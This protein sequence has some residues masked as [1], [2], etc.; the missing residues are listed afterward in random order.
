MSGLTMKSRLLT[1][2]T[3]TFMEARQE[4]R[5]LQRKYDNLKKRTD[6][7]RKNATELYAQSQRRYDALSAKHN[8]LLAAVRAFC[9]E[10]DMEYEGK[11]GAALRQFVWDESDDEAL[12]EMEGR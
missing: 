8:E 2:D 11:L 3:E 12:R 7:F 9:D 10:S 4:K 6:N 1:M 5:A